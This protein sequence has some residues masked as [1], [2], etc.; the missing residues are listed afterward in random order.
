VVQGV[1]DTFAMYATGRP[2]IEYADAEPTGKPAEPYIIVADRGRFKGNDRLWAGGKAT[3]DR[4][5][6][7]ARG[8]SLRLDTGKGSDGSL[9]GGAPLMRGLGRD[10]FSLAGKRLDLKLQGGADTHRRRQSQGHDIYEAHE[11]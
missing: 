11:Q 3:I 1:R 7:A 8:D 9:V 10:S 2:R 4:S 6:F 5:D